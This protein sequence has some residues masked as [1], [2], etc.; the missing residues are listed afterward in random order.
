M[1]R[2]YLPFITYSQ[3]R[4][5]FLAHRE[6][7]LWGLVLHGHSPRGDVDRRLEAGATEYRI[8]TGSAVHL[9]IVDTISE[10]DRG[11]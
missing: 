11:Q 4:M 3:Q 1:P 9:L 8:R 6:P 10:L 5:L 2:H 7:R